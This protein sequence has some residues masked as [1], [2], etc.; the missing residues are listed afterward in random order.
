M[1]ENMMKYEKTW[2][3]FQIFLSH[4]FGCDY[5]IY[6]YLQLSIMPFF[7]DEKTNISVDPVKDSYVLR[8]KKSGYMIYS[9]NE[10][11]K[12]KPEAT[13]KACE[14]AFEIYEEQL[15]K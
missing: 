2:N 8:D 11:Y 12:N 7:F 9:P 13:I 5:K 6:D 1:F 3:E 14:K 4:K 10:H 15:Q